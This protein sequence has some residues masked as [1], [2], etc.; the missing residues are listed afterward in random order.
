MTFTR[1]FRRERQHYM[2][3]LKK[4]KVWSARILRYHSFLSHSPIPFT[5]N[6]C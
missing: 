6:P 1:A 4:W 2:R 5:Q 3:P